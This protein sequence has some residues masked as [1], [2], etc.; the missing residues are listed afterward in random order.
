MIKNFITVEINGKPHYP[1]YQF[2]SMTCRSISAIRNLMFKGNKLRKL[3]YIEEPKGQ[4]YIPVEEYTEFPFTSTG[5]FAVN[6]VFHYTEDHQ[7][8]EYDEHELVNLFRSLN[9]E[10]LLKEKCNGKAHHAVNS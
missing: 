5:R 8:V 3:K 10:H 7:F 2:A 9:K 6:K 1:M 4:Y